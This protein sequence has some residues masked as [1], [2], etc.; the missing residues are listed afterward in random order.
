MIR[1]KKAAIDMKKRTTAEL[2]YGALFAALTAGLSQL[3][4]PIGPVPVNLATFSV[5][6][7]GVVLGSRAG[8]W[9]MATYV[10]LG[11]AGLPVFAGSRGGPGALA[12]PT[13]GYLAGYV[14]AA[15]L[16]GF[17][18]ERLPKKSVFAALAMAGGLLACYALGTAWFVFSTH[19]PFLRALGLCVVPFLPG[20]ALKIAL[21]AAL[22]FRLR[23][24]AGVR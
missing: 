24:A 16:V 3:S 23:R 1:G 15:W 9:S 21:A 18:S 4:I 13:G 6:L 17:F 11:L 19:T 20:D 2:V 5:L 14:A 12:G 22:A 7:A 8:A 10:L